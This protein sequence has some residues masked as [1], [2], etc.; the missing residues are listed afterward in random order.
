MKF[1]QLV[2]VAAFSLTYFAVS[3]DA[4][5]RTTRR[6]PAPKVVRTTTVPQPAA[7]SLKAGSE[8]V[9]IQIKNVTKFLYLLGGVA[10]GIEGIDKDPRANQ[11][12]KNA[13]EENKRAVMQTIRNLRAGLAALEVEFRTNPALKPH[14]V[15]IQG[16]ADLTGETELLANAGKFTESGKPLL[17]VVERLSDT[18]AA[19]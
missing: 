14:L 13:N 16:I 12:A 18:L 1:L 4:Q 9:S 17:R 11:A 8:K 15:H 5:R 2:L 7:T 10:S 19:L 6:P 3:A